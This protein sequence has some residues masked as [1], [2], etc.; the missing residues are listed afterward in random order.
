MD[1]AKLLI[2]L[3]AIGALLYCAFL[4]DQMMVNDDELYAKLLRGFARTC[5]FIAG[6]VGYAGVLAE[7]EYAKVMELGRMN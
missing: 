1:R 3:E 7:R 4:I 6:H 5:R 2:V